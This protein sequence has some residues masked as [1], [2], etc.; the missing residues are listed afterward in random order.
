[1]KRGWGCKGEVGKGVR[2]GKHTG[3]STQVLS[4][5]SP[6]EPWDVYMLHIIISRP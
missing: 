1:M 6:I 2:Q 4:P 5:K 3:N